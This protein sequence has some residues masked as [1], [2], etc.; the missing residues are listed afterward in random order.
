M[1]RRLGD[2]H[3][4]NGI[5]HLSRK[6]AKLVHCTLDSMLNRLDSEPGNS[7]VVSLYQRNTIV[8]QME[9]AYR[10]NTA[11]TDREMRALDGVREVYG[12]RRVKLNE[13]EKTIRVEYDASRMK[14]PVIAS[15][16]RKAGM[17][18]R[19]KLALA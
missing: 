10:Y 14:E 2:I 16:L 8:T 13:N 17:D 1:E 11:P 4:T 12:I 6:L 18:L 9:V 5:F 3:P 19:E 7:N 15:L